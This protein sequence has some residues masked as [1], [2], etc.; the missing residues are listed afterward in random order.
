MPAGSLKILKARRTY[1]G[2]YRSFGT[3]IKNYADIP[4]VN[5]DIVGLNWIPIVMIIDK[6]TP[7]YPP[8]FKKYSYWGK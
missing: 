3:K 8:L 2:G 6:G 4:T 1:E 7:A 5:A